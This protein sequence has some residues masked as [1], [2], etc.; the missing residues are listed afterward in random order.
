VYEQ[1]KTLIENPRYEMNDQGKVRVRVGQRN[2]GHVLRQFRKN[3][4]MCVEVWRGTKHTTLR[5]WMLMEKYWPRIRYPRDWKPKDRAKQKPD[6]SDGRVKLT[7]EQVHEIMESK[8]TPSQIARTGK[9]P[10]GRRHISRIKNG[11]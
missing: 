10:V 4:S 1:W 5:L 6:K 2:A 3:G 8:L 7:E 11:A 9:Y